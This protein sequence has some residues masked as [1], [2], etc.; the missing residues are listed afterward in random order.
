MSDDNAPRIT[1]PLS[2]ILASGDSGT[3]AARPG[4]RRDGAETMDLKALARLVIERDST[5]DGYR[6]RLSRDT[7]SV[8][9]GMWLELTMA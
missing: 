6:D 2:Q 8:P 9:S 5:R 3:L 7:H 4:Q 1:V